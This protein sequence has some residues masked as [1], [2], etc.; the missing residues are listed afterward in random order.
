MT[1]SLIKGRFISL[2]FMFCLFF[3]WPLLTVLLLFIFIQVHIKKMD[4]LS[5]SKI[6][7][8]ICDNKLSSCAQFAPRANVHLGAN[9]LHPI[10]TTYKGGA[11]SHS[12]ANLLH[13][14]PFT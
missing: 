3:E 12:G 8:Y 11:N 9:L 4:N 13:K 5:K 7:L 10:C 6:K 14:T 1:L 2:R